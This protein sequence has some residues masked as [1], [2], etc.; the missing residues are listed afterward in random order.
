VN[1]VRHGSL[2]AGVR[3]EYYVDLTRF[4]LTQAMRPHFVVRS[5][6]DLGLLGPA[7]RSAVRGVDPQLGVD[8]SQQ[9][10]AELVSASIAKPR[11]NTFV[12]GGFALVALALAAVGIYGVMSHA[13]T[14]RTREIGIRMAIGA[15]PSRVLADVLRQSLTLSGLGAAIGLLGAAAV[16]RYL[17]SMLFELTPLDPSTFLGV[18]VLVLF[19]ALLASY[20]PA[21]RASRVDPLV[22][23]RHD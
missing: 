5:T 4:G 11:F 15:A 10:M 12:L 7:V 17:E 9:T 22:A 23:L 1:D 20:V 16:T 3:A 19:V 21:A 13:V 6:A 18:A 2:A 14:R 8:L